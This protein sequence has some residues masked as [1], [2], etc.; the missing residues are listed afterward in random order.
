MARLTVNKR[1]V[2]Q[3]FGDLSEMPIEV[4]EDAGEYFKKITPKNKGN[5]QNNTK[6]KETTI[7]AGYPYAGRLDDGWSKKAPKGMSGPTEKEIDNLIDDYI[8]KVT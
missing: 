1:E 5:A 7:T 3:M 2:M 4:M 6:T 8:K